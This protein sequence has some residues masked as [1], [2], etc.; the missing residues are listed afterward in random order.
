MNDISILE[1]DLS[2]EMQN[3]Q[4]RIFKAYCWL[5]VGDFVRLEILKNVIK[6]IDFLQ[7]FFFKMINEVK[8]G[9]HINQ[10]PKIFVVLLT[11]IEWIVQGAAINLMKVVVCAFKRAQPNL[12][13]MDS[14]VR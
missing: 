12:F 10:L 9:V 14:L 1:K 5:N 8:C 3:K 2:E 13:C 7:F 6:K 4:T 11:Y